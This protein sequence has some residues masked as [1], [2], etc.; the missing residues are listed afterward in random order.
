MTG[1]T[2]NVDCFARVRDGRLEHKL[3]CRECGWESGVFDTEDTARGAAG[4]HIENGHNVGGDLE[5]VV[6]DELAGRSLDEIR[7]LGR[8]GDR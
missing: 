6:D 7:R 4:A 8:D 3:R 5:V 1:E 2:V